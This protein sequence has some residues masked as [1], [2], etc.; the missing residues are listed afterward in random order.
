[1]MEACL[2]P[3]ALVGDFLAFLAA[4]SFTAGSGFLLSLDFR[5]EA[6]CAHSRYFVVS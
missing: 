5:T 6:A 2:D 1:M 4:G 3:D